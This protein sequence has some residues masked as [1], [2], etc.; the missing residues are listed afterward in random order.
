M[1]QLHN[2]FINY[3][4]KC[5][6][7]LQKLTYYFICVA[8]CK[9]VNPGEDGGGGDNMSYPPHVLTLKS[10]FF[11]VRTGKLIMFYNVCF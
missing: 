11:F 8:A 3:N 9:G 1:P 10:V 7:L 6:I 2:L 5:C 4:D